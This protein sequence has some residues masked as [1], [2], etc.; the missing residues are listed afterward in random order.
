M[1]KKLSVQ[2]Q[3]PRK[4]SASGKAMQAMPSAKSAT[5]TGQRM[6]R[7]TPSTSTIRYMS[8]S[9]P[10]DQSE[11]LTSSPTGLSTNITP[12]SSWTR[13]SKKEL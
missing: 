2:P 5:Q 4:L 9:Q 8:N 1:A 10:S 7:S 11:P 12:G 13:M 3:P 6:S